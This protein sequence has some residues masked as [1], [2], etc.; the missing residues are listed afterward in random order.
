MTFEGR[1]QVR[2]DLL[3]WKLYSEIVK[4][5]R[6]QILDV[7]E[8]FKSHNFCSNSAE[9]CSYHISGGIGVRM[10]I[11]VCATEISS[12]R[13]LDDAELQFDERFA[14]GILLL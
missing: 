8:K 11:V 14:I 10:R 5:F 6:S 13:F 7:A 12:A 9:C 2:Q 4:T 3:L 1:R